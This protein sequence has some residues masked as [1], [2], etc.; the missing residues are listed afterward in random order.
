MNIHEYQAKEILKNYGL[1]VLKGK[2]YNKNLE[3][4]DADIKDLKG[5]P[6]V[7]KSQIHAGGRGAGHFKNSFNDKGGVQ[8][9]FDKDNVSSVAKSMMGNV[10]VTKQTGVIGKTVNRIFIEEGCDIDR[11]FYLSLLVDRNTSKV[12]MMISAAGGMDIEEVAITNPEKIINVHFTKYTDISLDDS[13]LTK[14]DITKNQLDELT[15]II[16]K[17]LNAFTSIDASTIEINPLVLNK[18]GSFVILDAKI[19]LDDNALFRHPELL[20]LKDL[21]EED[22]LELQAAEHDM[23][24]VKLDGSIGCMVNGAGLAMAT[25]DIIKQFGEEPANFLDLGGTANKDRVI[26]GFK[27]IQSDPNVKSILINI[28]GGIIHCDMIANGIV[29]AVKEL[30]FKLPLV[31]RFQGTNAKEGKD[32]INNSDLGLISIDDFTEAAKKVVELAKV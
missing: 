19:S 5:P 6:W 16:N 26:M 10:L 32:K 24:Y 13:L 23:N 28:F 22:P 31:V 8:V 15:S 14:L 1:P 9:I 27:T 21:T 30:D 29:D 20:D 25:M 11:E 18:Q 7:V 12:M 3:T 17:L 2:S 4:L